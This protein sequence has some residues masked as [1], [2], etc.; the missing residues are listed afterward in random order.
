VG[1]GS[2][3]GVVVFTFILKGGGNGTLNEV[4]AGGRH[5]PRQALDPVSMAAAM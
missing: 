2:A 1:F 5:E 3:T 4:R